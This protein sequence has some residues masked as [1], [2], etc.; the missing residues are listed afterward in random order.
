VILMDEATA[1]VDQDTDAA[2]QRTIRECF[3]DKTILVIA[4]RLVTIMDFD[5]IL[6]MADGHVG[7]FDTPANLLRAEG[8]LHGMVEETGPQMAADLHRIAMAQEAKE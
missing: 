7:E 1:S 6:V 3:A 4:H 2:I 8:L 5:R